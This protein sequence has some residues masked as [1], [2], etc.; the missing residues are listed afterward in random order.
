MKNAT[1]YITKNLVISIVVFL[2]IAAILS[3]Y[4]LS[5]SEPEKIQVSQLITQINEGQVKTVVVKGD[6]LEIELIN[7]AKQKTEKESG[8]SLS[9]LLSNYE[10]T[11][12]KMAEIEVDIQ[13]QSG[14]GYWLRVLLP[15]LL[16]FALIAFF[17]WIMMRQVQGANN[18]A[19][20]FGSSSAREIPKNSKDKVTFKD[21]AGVKEAKEE[22]MEVV[23]FLKSPKKFINLGAK[24]PKGVLLMGSPGTGKTLLARA[25]AGE[26]N[27]P[28]FHISGSEFV[29]MFVGVG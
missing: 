6:V 3:T 2:I 11:P 24:I 16:P 8:E 27:V 5:N 25:V 4:S 15:F 13:G 9:T 22:L 19:M 28:F 10:I 29:E 1:K 14:L 23:E 17:I 18:R 12:E 26:A 21:V 20:T 7:G